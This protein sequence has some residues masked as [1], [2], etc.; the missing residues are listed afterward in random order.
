LNYMLHLIFEELLPLRQPAL[1]DFRTSP[2]CGELGS[3]V[4][5]L[6]D[7]YPSSFRSGHILPMP[8][9][10][11]SQQRRET[12]IDDPFPRRSRNQ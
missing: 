2:F 5:N 1:V 12:R 9:I 8:S 4:D 6:L 3:V 7:A 10:S 11:A